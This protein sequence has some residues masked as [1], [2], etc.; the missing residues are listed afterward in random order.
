MR[1]II[2]LRV[3]TDKQKQSMTGLI[4]Q[5]EACIA[6][7]KTEELTYHDTILAQFQPYHKLTI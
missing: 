2:Y 6:K 7:A 5:A 1:A 3:S 4:N